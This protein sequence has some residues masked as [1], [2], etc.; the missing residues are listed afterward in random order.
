MDFIQATRC[1]T[2]QNI[3]LQDSNGVPI[4]EVLINQG[5]KSSITLRSTF[6]FTTAH[7]IDVKYCT[8]TK[9][10]FEIFHIKKGVVKTQCRLVF[11][12][13]NDSLT[14]ES[15][16]VQIAALV[17][18]GVEESVHLLEFRQYK[19]VFKNILIQNYLIPPIMAS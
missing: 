6:P 19:S 5:E 17:T 3:Y 10:M 7:C 2:K 11:Y 14:Y 13:L 4:N 15:S 18:P 16:T 1:S 9:A 8:L 12:A